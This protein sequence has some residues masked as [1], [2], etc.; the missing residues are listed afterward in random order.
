MKK[1]KKILSFILASVMCIMCVSS[2]SAETIDNN[3]MVLENNSQECVVREVTDS[4][5]VIATNNKTTGILTVDTYDLEEKNIVSTQIL[6]LNAIEAGIENEISL[7][8]NDHMYQHT[9]SNREYDIY[10]YSSYTSW[11]L[12]SG[13]SRK[14]RTQTSSNISDLESFRGAVEDVNSA[15]YEIMINV[16][17]T[18]A[19][20]AITA[21]LTG[22]LAAGLAAAGGSAAVATAFTDLNSACNTADYYFNK[23]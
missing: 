17:T 22:G 10:Y 4:G 9:F 11:Q 14:T 19:I 2:V 6:D 7:A 12:R 8:A 5:I 3:I 15:E 13:D 1:Y 23:L 20:T 21:Y 18:A 16:G